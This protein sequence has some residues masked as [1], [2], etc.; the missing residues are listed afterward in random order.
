MIRR[1]GNVSMIGDITGLELRL[2]DY[3]RTLCKELNFTRASEVLGIS[4]P[5]L[6]NQI[7]L[8]EDRLGTL[9]FHRIGKKVYISQSGYILLEH[10]E[11]VFGELEQVT[12]K[13]QELQ[14]LNRGKIAIGCSGNHLVT[15]S[16]M[17]FHKKH[18]DIEVS[19]FDSSTE[20]L[21]EA[22]LN[23]Q[24]DLAVV[25]M[26]IPEKR[27][28]IIHLFDDELCLVVSSQHRLN[29]QKTISLNEIQSIDLA[30]LPQSL[31][32]RKLIDSY[33]HQK[34]FIVKP[35]LELS[36]LES[37][38]YFVLDHM[39]A[40][41]L[42]KSYLLLVSDPEHRIIS[43]TNPPLPIPIRIIYREESFSDPTINAFIRHLKEDY[44]KLESFNFN[45][46]EAFN[47][48]SN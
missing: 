17:A 36:Q 12:I 35:K 7:K 31:Y 24:L 34:G 39:T 46:F 4:Q 16:V 15:P 43:I 8:L 11:K 13:V 45:R 5:T 2:L 28:K 44:L 40:A 32:I 19:V 14:G 48:N 23:N 3:F 10:T 30:L 37:L 21:T 47:F 42:P 25:F 29:D 38:R 26:T 18:S 1:G 27:L 9:L 41:I 33:C 22:V 20:N 6:S